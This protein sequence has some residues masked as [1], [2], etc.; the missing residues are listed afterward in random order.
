M[1]DHSYVTEVKAWLTPEGPATVSAT[2]PVTDELSPRLCG[3]CG[4]PLPDKRKRFHTKACQGKW[5]G[6]W[7]AARK[8]AAKENSA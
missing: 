1:E 3:G 6:T 8:A 7:D 5:L 4:N 2:L